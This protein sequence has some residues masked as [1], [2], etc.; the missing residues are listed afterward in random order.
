[1]IRIIRIIGGV[2]LKP[3]NAKVR[4]IVPL[5]VSFI[6]VIAFQAIPV[7]ATSFDYGNHGHW[8]WCNSFSNNESG[9]VGARGHISGGSGFAWANVGN[10]YNLSESMLIDVN[11]KIKLN[12]YLFAQRWWYLPATAGLEVWIIVYE[13]RPE[14]PG[15]YSLEWKECVHS[16]WIFFSGHYTYSDEILYLSS[17]P[18]MEFNDLSIIVYVELNVRTIDGLAYVYE[19]GDSDDCATMKIYYIYVTE[20]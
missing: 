15:F 13:E 8:P 6:V 14:N 12:A 10:L 7:S 5:I 1:L 3:C 9:I 11:I 2:K 4:L 20:Q 18:T 16:K 17:S 19:P